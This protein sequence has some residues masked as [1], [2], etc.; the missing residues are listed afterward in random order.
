MYTDKNSF[1]RDVKKYIFSLS[2]I[3]CVRLP[4]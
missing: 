1:T 3:R 2:E 4:R